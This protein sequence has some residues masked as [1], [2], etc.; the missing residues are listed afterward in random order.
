MLDERMTGNFHRHGLISCIDHPGEK[1]LKI[2][3]LRG[4]AGRIHLQFSDAIFHR[5]D[6]AATA[7]VSI[8]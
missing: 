4:S 8:Q 6:Q 2:E 7:L 5:P 1:F 3:R